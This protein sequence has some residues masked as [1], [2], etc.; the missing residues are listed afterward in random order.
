MN[1]SFLKRIG[2]SFFFY[3]ILIFSSFYFF[4]YKKNEIKKFLNK[5]ET[6]CEISI[7]ICIKKFEFFYSKRKKKKNSCTL[8]GKN[9][10]LIQVH[11][12]RVAHEN[13]RDKENCKRVFSFCTFDVKI[14]R[15]LKVAKYGLLPWRQCTSK[16]SL[17]RG[18][19]ERIERKC[20]NVGSCLSRCF[21][22]WCQERDVSSKPLERGF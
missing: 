8:Q 10:I 1:K 13:E 9:K 16:Y 20:P 21:N 14:R 11:M 17:E 6:C 7:T 2:C 15:N 12:C 19:L 3:I 22:R 18:V 5:I 4:V